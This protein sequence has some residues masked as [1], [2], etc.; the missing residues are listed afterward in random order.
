M[1]KTASARAGEIDDCELYLGDCLEVLP[2]IDP[3]SFDSCVTDPPYHLTANKKGGSGD[4]SVNLDSPYGRSRI[5]TGSMGKK[6]DGGDVAFRVETWQAVYRVMKPGAYLVAFGGT[7]TQHRMV[8]AIEDAGFEIRDGLIWA[9]GSG[10]PKSLNVGAKTGASQWQGWGTA[11]KPAFEPIVLAR[12]PLS[13]KTVASNALRHGTGAINVDGCRVATNPDVDDKRLGGKG[14]WS[15]AKMAKNVYEGGYAGERVGSSEL[16]RFPPN[17][18]HDGSPE[19]LAAF[20]RFGEKA[21]GTA[22][23]FFPALGYGA[24]DLAF[25]YSGKATKADRAGSN[26]PTVKPIALMRWLCRLITP[27]GGRVLDPFAGSGTT[28]AAALRE[29]F[30]P[31]GIE[32]EA[33]HHADIVAR[34]KRMAF[35]DWM[36]GSSG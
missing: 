22:A 26:H 2:G 23:R 32:L 24:D 25:H 20:A 28:L 36:R 10:F 29:G 21:S 16:G 18:S 35:D 15:S 7:R 3:D 12:K 17:L 14:T 34:L 30:L 33:E 19:V 27:P 5:G 1:S 6:W 4:A 8:C 11:L 31:T 13:E 9:Y